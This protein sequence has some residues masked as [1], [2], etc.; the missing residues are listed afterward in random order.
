M[1][2]LGRCVVRSRGKL[3]TI[4]VFLLVAAIAAGAVVYLTGPEKKEIIKFGIWLDYAAAASIGDMTERAG[5]IV[6][7][8]FE[9]RDEAVSLPGETGVSRSFFTFVVSEVL[10][11]ELNDE[12]IPVSE[13][14]SDSASVTVSDAVYENGLLVKSASES[15]T[16]SFRYVSPFYVEPEIGA[17][18]ILFLSREFVI[19][20]G[21]SSSIRM[22]M[23]TTQPYMFK[24]DE[25][26]V[27]SLQSGLLE[28]GRQLL[29]QEIDIAPGLAVEVDFGSMPQP[30]YVSGMT[31]EEIKQ[32]IENVS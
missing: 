5:V 25:N 19:N 32:E 1:K 30:D 28:P 15:K 4:L 17:E 12:K 27:A 6:M 13:I 2:R 3:L 11:G 26:G 9:S 18:Y 8:R 23:G 14:Y 31:L 16:Y 22:Y 7:G 21:S 29:K 20:P 24:L 10:K